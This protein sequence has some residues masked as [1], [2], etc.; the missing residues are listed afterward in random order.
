MANRRKQIEAL[1]Q[2][3]S[4]LATEFEELHDDMES[5]LENMPESLQYG[6][7]GQAIQE[8]IDWL[9]TCVDSLNEIAEE[10]IV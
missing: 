2:K 10:V 8:K 3:A 9:D 7:R 4:E 6:E 5:A 1:Q